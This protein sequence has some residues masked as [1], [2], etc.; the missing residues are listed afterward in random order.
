MGLVLVL[1]ATAC[2]DPKP[3]G[4]APTPARPGWTQV[5]VDNFDGA[6]N[7]GLSRSDWLY[8]VG[9]GYPGGAPQWGTFE[10]ET[11]ATNHGFFLILNVAIGGVFTDNFGGGPTAATKSGVPML[12]DRVAVFTSAGTS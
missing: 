3:A 7:T 5:F 8:S 12:V 4:P 2:T 1:V 10:L 9:T 6:A 11:N